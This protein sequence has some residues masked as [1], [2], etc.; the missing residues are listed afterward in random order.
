MAKIIT[1]HTTYKGYTA[2]QHENIFDIFPDF[3]N[4][5]KPKR[6]LEIG[7]AGGGF[8]LFIRDLLN[9]IGL[10]DTEIRTFDIVQQSY[11]KELVENNINVNIKNIFN[12][13]YNKLIDYDNIKNYI[14]DE[15]TTLVFCDGGYKKGEFNMLSDLL[16]TGDYIMAHDYI[17]DQDTFINKFKNN[18]WDWCEII[19]SDIIDA[20]ERN[21]LVDYYNDKLN[22]V[23]WVCKKKV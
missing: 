10:N 6:I 18:I 3:I 16:K 9:S 4:N 22:E 5:I 12:Y 8:I 13:E 1:G 14:S 23:V 15:G 20:C 17:K 19:E 2:Q 21:N 7:T 11:Y